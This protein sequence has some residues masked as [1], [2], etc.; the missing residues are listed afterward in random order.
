MTSSRG[1]GGCSVGLLSA[2]VC[3]A[4]LT[5]PAS[6]AQAWPVAPSVEAP[7]CDPGQGCSG[8]APDAQ[9]PEGGAAAGS[10]PASPPDTTPPLP[11]PTGVVPPVADAEEPRAARAPLSPAPGSQPVA[12]VPELVPDRILMLD[13]GLHTLVGDGSDNFYPGL[14]TGLLVG[15]RL[16]R[17]V[18]GNAEVVVDLLNPDTP[19]GVSVTEVFFDLT[20]SPLLHVPLSPTTQFILGPRLGV[21]Y[22][23]ESASFQAQSVTVWGWGWALGGNAGILSAQSTTRVGVLAS[24]NARSPM[25]VCA[26]SSSIAET[27]APAED[28]HAAK[29]LSLAFLVML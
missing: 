11:A 4:A 20:F 27:C 15:G 17:Q 29:M 25:K 14:R 6:T 9:P 19:S 7:P 28:L 21:F 22:L 26:D 2:T 8:A 12:V 24:F 18:S 16:G 5:F 13:V 10:P 3:L 1:A 23:H